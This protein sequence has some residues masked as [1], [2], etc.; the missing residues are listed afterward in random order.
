MPKLIL[1]GDARG[2]VKAVADLNAAYKQT[3]GELGKTA[4]AA[5]QLQREAAKIV[6][7]NMGPQDRY[8]QSVKR[9]AELVK[10]G[11]LSFDQAEIA[12]KR[13]RT[14]LDRA[15]GS[16]AL[17]M[18]K[19]HVNDFTSLAGAIALVGKS[20]RDMEADAQ[21]A[22]DAVFNAVGSAGQLQQLADFPGGVAYARQLIRQ[23]VVPATNQSQA[24]DIAYDLGS[25]NF[26]RGEMQY[27][28]EIGA[29]K[30]V[31]PEGLVSFGGAL[32]KYI[33]TFGEQ[34]AGSLRQVGSKIFEAAAIAQADAVKVAL[35]ATRFG[36]G[37]QSLGMS[38][39]EAMAAFL[40]IEKQAPNPEQASTRLEALLA[41]IDKRGLKKGTFRQTIDSILQ[42]VERGENPYAILGEANA[43]QGFRNI[44]KEG[45]FI[46]QTEQRLQRANARDVVAGA[47]PIMQDPALA[48]SVIR[49]QAEGRLAAIQES[50]D[51]VRENLF[52]AVVAER[53]ARLQ[54]QG[55]YVGA[56]QMEM[57]VARVID[58][59]GL[60][61]LALR[62]E[63]VQE[64]LGRGSFSPELTKQLEAYFTRS[65]KA[66]ESIDKKTPPARTV[67][68]LTG[69]QE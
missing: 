40:A 26:T 51:A 4:L 46:Q 9:L 54:E 31:K 39:E 10:A 49:Q 22:A 50:R 3:T 68:A 64:R 16:S 29:Q 66:L 6:R 36:S 60:E 45:A 59:L 30:R 17:Q 62:G 67:P 18:L 43:V 55:S 7:D 15:V 25:A 24:F 53:K 13:Y 57:L 1:D 63:M 19:T 33:G 69:R 48:A 65:T 35:A 8:N 38:D 37:S 23:G 34:E 41:Q 5:K 32:K 12:A 28:A 56:G 42:R 21:A 2:A 52:D 20:L 58:F 44:A 27:I 11:A 47:A 14:T 61:D